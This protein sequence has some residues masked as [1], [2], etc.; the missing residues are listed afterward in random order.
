MKVYNLSV[1]QRL[2]DYYFAHAE[3]LRFLRTRI[4][5]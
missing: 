4:S 2:F 5:I 3:T 1:D